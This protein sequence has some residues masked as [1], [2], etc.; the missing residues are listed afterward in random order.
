MVTL[1]SSTVLHPHTYNTHRLYVVIFISN[2]IS[3][4]QGDFIEGSGSQT[5]L[6]SLM[7]CEMFERIHW[8][9]LWVPVVF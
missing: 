5:M 1:K 9:I 8:K 2:S 6:G 4:S 3:R 7:V